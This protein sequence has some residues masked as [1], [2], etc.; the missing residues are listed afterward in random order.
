MATP[1]T[2]RLSGRERPDD[3]WGLHADG[4]RHQ[5]HRPEVYADQGF[6]R[7]DR[8]R[9]IKEMCNRGDVATSVTCIVTIDDEPQD[10]DRFEIARRLKR[11]KLL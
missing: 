3:P 8:D 7:I 6:E 9:A 1:S 2:G 11:S 10:H 4:H 5:R